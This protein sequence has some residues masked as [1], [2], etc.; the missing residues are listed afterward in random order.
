[1]T[2]H[3]RK[4]FTL[5]E[6]LVVI[7]IIAILAAIL[8]PV[9]AKAREQARKTSCGSNM[10]Q[11]GI[12]FAQYA[13]DYDECYAT[14]NYASSGKG[15]AQQLYPYVKSVGAYQCA[16]DANSG[17]TFFN[18]QYYRLSYGYNEALTKLLSSGGSAVPNLSKLTSSPQT[19]TLYEVAYSCA[20]IAAPNV[21]KDDCTGFGSFSDVS[22]FGKDAAGNNKN[23]TP[24]TGYLGGVFSSA[25][26]TWWA[27]VSATGRHTDGANY[28]LCDG[29][30]K[31]LKG[32]KVSPGACAWDQNDAQA[33]H[34]YAGNVPT[35][36]GTAVNT[37]T[38]TFSPV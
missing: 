3:N 9:F 28:L 34:V 13:Q 1:M 38:A 7:A 30:V 25:Y 8:F 15:W 36:A 20:T 21:E 24:D 32:E 27:P 12:A 19:V 33:A 37:Y 29:H 6:L 22:G 10:K 31:W 26:S 5:I 16:D 23:C 35:A 17:E 2:G 14:G 11:L 18:Y 4:G